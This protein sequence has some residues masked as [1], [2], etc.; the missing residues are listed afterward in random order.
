MDQ[1]ELSQ[2]YRELQQ[3]VSSALEVLRKSVVDEELFHVSTFRTSFTAIKGTL[4]CSRALIS[5]MTS[6][7]VVVK[8]ESVSIITLR[9]SRVKRRP[10]V[11]RSTLKS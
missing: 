5:T 8:T 10:E 1:R 3:H 11:V 9:L 2:Q 6:V 4:S 7:Q